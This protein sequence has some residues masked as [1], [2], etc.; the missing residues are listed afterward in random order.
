MPAGAQGLRAQDRA[1]TVG[2]VERTYLLHVPANVQRPAPVVMVFHGGGGRAQGIMR[3]T[4]INELADRERFI[5]VYPQGIGRER[6]GTWNIGGPDSPSTADDV[7][8]VKAILADLERGNAIDRRRIYATGESMGGVFAYRLAC[9]M[10]DTFAAI[11]PVAATMVN[12]GC[13]PR[14]PVAVFHVHGSADEN[15][16]IKGGIGLMSA[17]GRTWPA[18][19]GGL[20]Q[21]VKFD[22]CAGPPKTRQDGPETT[23]YSYDGCAATVE[24][25]VVN[26][27]GHAWPGS[28]PHRW[29]ERFGVYVSQTFPTSL[30]IWQFFAAH[31]KS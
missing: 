9:E 26:G 29:Q 11:A 7:G 4:R 19:E 22:R 15:V 27:G 14:N 21:W 10:S 5:A 20:Q 18:I 30:R 31:P 16:P 12:P 8:F 23:C 3:T 6:G 2:G 17:R 24:Y 1:V 25:C 28:E 13:A